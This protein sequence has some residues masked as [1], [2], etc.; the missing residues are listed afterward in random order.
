MG[1]PKINGLNSGIPKGQATL[2]EKQLMRINKAD[3]SGIQTVAAKTFMRYL[4]AN[5]RDRQ[6]CVF[7]IRSLFLFKGLLG[8][9]MN[10]FTQVFYLFRIVSFS[11]QVC[12]R[13]Q[14]S[15]ISHLETTKNTGNLSTDVVDSV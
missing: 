14:F 10:P 13:K 15:T 4:E 6:N 11:Q 12:I 3:T 1:S 2:L 7:R 9:I 8:Q 5:S